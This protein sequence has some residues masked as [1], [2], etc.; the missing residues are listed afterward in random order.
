MVKTILWFAR[1]I[2]SFI[3]LL[4]KMHRCKKAKATLPMSESKPIIDKV[5][6]TWLKK[7]LDF[8][9][10]TYEITGKERIPDRPVLYVANHQGVF[11]FPA[12]LFCT[13]TPCGFVAKKETLK[14]PLIRTW[15]SLID[16]VFIDRQNPREAMKAINET[17]DKLNEGKSMTIFPE[18]TRSKDGQLGE[19]KGGAFKIAQKTRAPIVPVYIKGTRAAFEENKRIRKAVVHVTILEPIYTEE[20]TREEF[21]ALPE[22]VKQ[23]IQDEKDK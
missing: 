4:P 15:M 16:C 8:A 20:L 3:L 11:D 7:Q 18:G 12:L 19:F 2:F 1:F 23:M 6:L 9:G 10:V 22:K 13:K 5:L 21:K 17:V 14:L